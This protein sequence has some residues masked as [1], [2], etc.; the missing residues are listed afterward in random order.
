MLVGRAAGAQVLTGSLTGTVQDESGGVLAAAVVRARSS[1]LI[2]GAVVV[3]TDERGVFRLTTLPPGDYTLEIEL[4]SFASYREGGIRVDVE[5]RIERSITLTIAGV[6]ES[7]SVEGGSTVDAGRSGLASR[8]DAQEL[9]AIPV[10]RFS[11]F[12]F[13]KAAPGVSPTSP[14]SGADPSVSVFGSGGNESLYLLDGTNFTCP[15]SGGPQPQPDV[16]VIEEVHVDSVGASAEF[17]NIQGAVFNVVT[18]QGGNVFAPDLSYYAQAQ[19]LTSQ[20]IELPCTR[21]SEPNTAYARVRYRDLTTHLGG[22][23]IANRAWFFGG[24]QYLRDSDSQPGTDPLFP[25][26]SEYD[27]GFAKVTWQISPQVRWMS[28]LH[29]ERWV[30][31]QRPTLVQPFE[32]TLRVSGTRPT[33]TFGQVSAAISSNTLVDARISRFSA[34]SVNDPSTGDRTVSNRTDLATGV[35]SGGPQGFGGGSL[36]RTTAAAS[37]SHYRRFLASSHDLKAGAQIEQGANT[38]WTSFPG[39]VVN[40]TDNAGQPVQATFRQPATSGGEFHDVGLYAMDAI[41]VTDRVTVNLGLRFDHDRAVSQDLPGHDALGTEVGVISGLGTLYS[42][43]VFSPRLGLTVRLTDDGKTMARASYGRFHQ[44]ILTG[45]LN[46]VHPGMT[47]IT[48]AGFDRST[49]S[50]SRVISVVDPTINVRLDP[51][52][53]SPRTDQIGIGVDRELA[54]HTTV[55]ISYVRK[56]GSDFIGW[57][58]TGGVYRPDTRTLADGRIIPVLVLANLPAARRFLLTNPP[59]YFIRYNGVTTAF[60]RRWSGRWQALAS[61]TLSKT[62]GL[63]SSSGSPAGL[64]QFS[65]TFGNAVTFGRDPNTLTN[66]TGVLPNDR[67]HVFRVMGSVAIPRTGFVLA[68]NLQSLTGSPWAATA[69]VSLPQGLTRVL[70]E[71]P[72]TRRL[73]SQ[74]L[75]DLRLSH[76]FD[77]PHNGRVELLLDV[78]NAFN[79][80]SEERLADDNYLSQNFA[81]PSVY[82]DP[83]RAMLGARLTF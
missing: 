8:F 62:E 34:P 27:K 61:Y 4:A 23:L 53:K 36:S 41:R 72:G 7:I 67:T 44:G 65:S 17:G 64:G 28:S 48:T 56:N 42:W 82:V 76:V 78:L 29:D 12:D 57:T 25:R 69:Q 63:E 38:G 26:V 40:Y 46:P 74:R 50:Y 60:E 31:P 30:T 33:A 11:M 51:D 43:N 21:C 14:S 15:C 6:A 13:I 10:R 37:I 77:L 19:S 22:P 83:R 59:D 24:Y 71:T 81:K 2:G 70:L 20:P 55:T 32:T 5:S 66:A 47:P 54:N 79:Q 68:A 52:M 1:S 75:L 16:D 3:T 58:D 45:E 35:Q 39:G 18:K 9:R 49:G 73:S 80:T